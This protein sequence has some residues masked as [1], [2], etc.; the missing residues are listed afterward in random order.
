MLQSGFN[1]LLQVE[2]SRTSQS[3]FASIRNFTSDHLLLITVIVVR[4]KDS[5]DRQS[6]ELDLVLKIDKFV[7][8]NVFAIDRKEPVAD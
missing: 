8:I 1:V 7:G 5:A 2:A 3:F 4:L 6:R